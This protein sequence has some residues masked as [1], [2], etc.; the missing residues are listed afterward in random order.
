MKRI[1]ILMVSLAFWTSLASAQDEGQGY[2][3]ETDPLVLKNLADEN[4]TSMP[5]EIRIGSH[6]PAWGARVTLLGTNSNLQWNA[7]GGGFTVTIPD[8][9]RANAPCRF[10]WTIKVT[11]LK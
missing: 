11:S 5:K 8:H 3:R 1:L 7:D 9:L 4:E 10:A 2:V 6:R